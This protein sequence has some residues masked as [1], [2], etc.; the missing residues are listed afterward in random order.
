MILRI[1]CNYKYK[2]Y[3]LKIGNIKD[4]KLMLQVLEMMKSLIQF[5]MRGKIMILG[6]MKLKINKELRKKMRKY[7][8][9]LRKRGNHLL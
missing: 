8:P 4:K 5:E 6:R 2:K 7:C 9:N 3:R 1:S